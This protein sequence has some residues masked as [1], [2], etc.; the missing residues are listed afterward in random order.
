[1]DTGG[2]KLS[3]LVD[4][5]M[6][7]EEDGR[8]REWMIEEAA[9]AGFSLFSPRRGYNDLEAVEQVAEWCSE[10]GML[11]MPWMQGTL[12]APEEGSEGRRLVWADG[13][14]QPVFSPNSDEFWDWTAKYVVQHA[15]ISRRFPNLI[16]VFLDYENYAAGKP[17]H[18][19][20]CYPI[21]Y[22]R[23]IL[24]AFGHH[25]GI[26][27]PEIAPAD[28]LEWLRKR[29][30]AESF[31]GY[32][33]RN[34]RERCRELREAVD[35]YNPG[36]RFCIY[37]APGTLFMTEACYP[38]W[39]TD[40]AP[41]M[42]ADA[43]SY[44]RR[45][46]FMTQTEALVEN[47]RRLLENMKMPE[48]AG[49]PFDYLGGIDPIVVG[50]DPEFCGRNAAAIAEMTAGYWVFY[51]GPEYRGDHPDYFRWFKWANSAMMEG[52]AEAWRGPRTTPDVWGITLREDDSR[53][54]LALAPRAT[55]AF[56]VPEPFEI[57][58]NATILV[59]TIPGKATEIGLATRA[60]EDS[61]PF[62][63]EILNPAMETTKEGS[64]PCGDDAM[65][66]FEAETGGVHMV[67]LSSEDGTYAIRST[68][69]ALGLYIG[70]GLLFHR[71]SPRLYFDVQK[72]IDDFSIAVR[73]TRD[74]TGRLRIFDPE[75]TL[76]AEAQTGIRQ[77]KAIA[78][79]A[80]GGRQGTW[81][82]EL[83]AAE[84]GILRDV[85]IQLLRPPQLLPVIA[86]EPGQ[87]FNGKIPR[88]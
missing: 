49:I 43:T 2:G 58:Y 6:E 71:G 19:G 53:R 51:E 39:A 81:S 33:I 45:S 88:A 73:G 8:T 23:E 40:S 77:R 84:E 3:I 27:I 18:E 60:L 50:A 48:A 7:R 37:P 85:S 69:A 12:Q 22:D 28:R 57:R 13:N 21:S 41:L 25:E 78:K 64:T 82:L 74:Q 30:L 29:D 14:E 1:M 17:R 38:E 31:S 62:R 9:A 86:M 61:G 56:R 72:G 11:H 68:N 42:L 66:S 4:K 55:G 65:I 35:A 10:H 76:A 54:V 67:R 80:V 44:G 20:N 32:Q 47:R 59:G 79:V 70:R 24:A 83:V 15:K 52:P 36:F 5:V 75:G 26:S 87:I 16:G 46:R 34:W 63:W